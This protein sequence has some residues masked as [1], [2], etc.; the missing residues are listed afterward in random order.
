[1]AI[2]KWLD[3]EGSPTEAALEKIRK[4]PYLDADGCLDFVASIWHIPSFGLSYELRPAEREVCHAEDGDSFVRFAT[5][6]WSGNEELIGALN[7]NQM[8][9]TLTWQISSRGGLHIYKRH[10]KPARAQGG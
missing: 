2:G 3:N 10:A 9:T 4:W 8:V 6:G 1:M 5:G 7:D